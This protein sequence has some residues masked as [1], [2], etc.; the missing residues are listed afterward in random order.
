MRT[1]LIDLAPR[2]CTNQEAL[3]LFCHRFIY[4]D[5]LPEECNPILMTEKYDRLTIEYTWNDTYTDDRVRTPRAGNY[6]CD[7][8]EDTIPS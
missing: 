3:I 2:V 6:A 4:V 7:F 5:K 1:R 8:T